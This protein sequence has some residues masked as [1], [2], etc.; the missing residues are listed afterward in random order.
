MN[1]ERSP[2]DAAKQ[3]E[4][5]LSM[6]PKKEKTLYLPMQVPMW[7]QIQLQRR[8]AK[9]RRNTIVAKKSRKINQGSLMHKIG[10]R[11][12]KLWAA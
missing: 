12:C 4:I 10:T 3:A 6:K 5:E 7:K 2:F 1:I 9:R 8:V 11:P